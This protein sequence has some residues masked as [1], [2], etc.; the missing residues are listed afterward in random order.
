MMVR[1]MAVCVSACEVRAAY[2][3]LVALPPREEL[4]ATMR[5][6]MK[7]QT[8]ISANFTRSGD[9]LLKEQPPCVRC[10]VDVF[11]YCESTGV[12]CKQ[13]KNY[14]SGSKGAHDEL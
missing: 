11:H 10:P 4:V 1:E 13:F 12:E 5:E 2:R 3:K 6:Y 14:A 7:L 8:D 9:A